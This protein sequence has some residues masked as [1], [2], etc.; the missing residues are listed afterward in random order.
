M[1]SLYTTNYFKICCSINKHTQE[2]SLVDSN[3]LLSL[4]SYVHFPQHLYFVQLILPWVYFCSHQSD[5]VQDLLTSSHAWRT[6]IICFPLCHLPHSPTTW[7]HQTLSIQVTLSCLSK[8]PFHSTLTVVNIYLVGF[9]F[10]HVM[11]VMDFSYIDSFIHF[12]I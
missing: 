11:S 4:H 5:L 2:K 1:N 9:E 7:N 6:I 3:T 12:Y 10:F 8:R